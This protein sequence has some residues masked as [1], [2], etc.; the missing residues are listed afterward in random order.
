[1]N[2]MTNITLAMPDEIYKLM[3]KHKDVKWTEIMRTAV[4]IKLN[5]LESV[6]QKT[7]K[8]KHVKETL[9]ELLN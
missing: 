4:M 9:D 6:R 1:M 3:K 5:Q 2:Y 8:L 7:E